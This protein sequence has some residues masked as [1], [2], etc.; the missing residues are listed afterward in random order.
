MVS[1]GMTNGMARNGI[2]SI[3][4][5]VVGRPATGVWAV[6]SRFVICARRGADSIVICVFREVDDEG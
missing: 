3:V 6:V 4:L 2:G 1:G 5:I